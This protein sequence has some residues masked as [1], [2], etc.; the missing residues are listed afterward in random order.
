VQQ[1]SRPT[2]TDV[3]RIAGVSKTT[4]SY[5]LSGPKERAARIS[6][7]TATR[8]LSAAQEVGYVPNESARSLRTRRTNRVLFLGN[9]LTSLYSQAMA[10]SIE[11][12]LASHGLTL[13]I[14]VGSTTEHIERAISLLTQHQADGLIVETS[15]LHLPELREAA[16]AG[17]KIVAIGPMSR[18]ARLDVMA[19]DFAPAVREAMEHLVGRH[20]R[21]FV[22]LHSTSTWEDDYRIR[23]ACQHLRELGVRDDDI[24]LLQ[25]P[26]D[27]MAAHECTL[28]FLADVPRPVAIYAGSDVSAIGVLWACIRLGASVPSE[29]GIVGH[30]NT[31]EIGITVPAITSLGPIASDFTRAAELM[32]SR[33]RK[34]SLPGRYVTEPYQFTVR[35]SSQQSLAP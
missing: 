11:Q 1:G 15:D 17:H 29:V 28:G 31:P 4:V 12:A 3:A 6:E 18:E 32:V 10:Q 26:H 23:V 30:G 14:Q 34:P 24:T 35:G 16:A 5:V 20:Y 2:I 19:S 25:C 27:R 22:L 9:R 13:G 8:V 7:E 33:L 21:H